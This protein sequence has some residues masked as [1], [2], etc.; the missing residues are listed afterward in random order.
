MHFSSSLILPKIWLIWKPKQH[1][2]LMI[3]L[4]FELLILWR[5]GQRVSLTFALESYRKRNKEQP[6]LICNWDMC[7]C[8][9]KQQSVREPAVHS[10]GWWASCP[11]WQRTRGSE[12]ERLL[13][14][15]QG[16]PPQGHSTHTHWFVVKI[17]A[18][19][20]VRY[21]FPLCPWWF[22]LTVT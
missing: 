22:Q 6:L 10:H 11:S 3:S 4:G 1:K 20:S 14:S 19:P 13:W 7:M 8:E 17:L 15:H 16:F 2:L 12:P 5:H 18:K 9:R 21:L